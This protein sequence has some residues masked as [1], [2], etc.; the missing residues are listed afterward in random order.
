LPSPRRRAAS[1]ME[2][3]SSAMAATWTRNGFVLN[4]PG[5]VEGSNFQI[6]WSPYEQ[7]DEQI[8]P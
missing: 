3:V 4:R 6:G 7:D 1:R 5:F 2:G 8:L